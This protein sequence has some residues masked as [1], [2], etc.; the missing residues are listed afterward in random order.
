ALAALMRSLGVEPD[1]IV[2]H[3]SGEFAALLAAGAVRLDDDEALVRCIEQ[4]CDSTAKMIGGDLV[5]EAAMTMVGGVGRGEVDACLKEA[6]DGLVVAMDN[7]PNQVVLVG[8]EQA[9]R[10]AV[11]RL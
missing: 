7:C 2:G 10:A 4:G 9:T 6:G 8:E 11:E 5:P 1:A 3:S